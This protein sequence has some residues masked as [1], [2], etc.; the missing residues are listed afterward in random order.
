MDFIDEVRTRSGRFAKR[1]EHLKD[2]EVTEEATK[3]SFILPFIQMLGYDIFNPAEVIPEFTADVGTKKGEKVD[4]A[5]MQAGTPAMLIECKKLGTDLAS[6]AI[7]Q[8]LRYFGVTESRIGILTDGINYRFFSDLD[9]SNV[10]D[11]RPFFEFNMLEFNEL[12]VKELKRFTKD[13]FDQSLITDAA[14]ELRYT[15]EIKRL[16]AQ[17]L[18]NPSDDFVKFVMKQVYEGRVS[19][20]TR[21]MFRSLTFSAFSQFISD[22]IQDRLENALKQEGDAV[23][24]SA[25]EEK[26]GTS[27][28]EFTQHEI[29]G[30]NI[31]KAILGGLED[32][33]CM[34][35]RSTQKASSV[36]LHKTPE[37]DDYGIVL[38][39][40]SARSPKSLKLLI[41]GKPSIDLGTMEDLYTHTDALRQYVRDRDAITK[42]GVS[43]DTPDGEN[44]GVQK[45]I[46]AQTD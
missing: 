44:Q 31:I 11:P 40:L 46:E 38:C 23:A 43:N 27:E 15:A 3:T 30:L 14:R 8:L 17:E 45:E 34:S 19:K 6:D 26:E 36:V 10:M 37:K 16:L 22:K 1:L 12:G 41:P 33:R 24:D 9:Q 25:R 18:A 35:L 7:S 39:R 5:L 20:A 4:F 2:K 32:V 42:V 29:V 28:S 13:E 21:E